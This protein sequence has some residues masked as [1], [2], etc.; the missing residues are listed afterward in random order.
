MTYDILIIGTG[1]SGLYCALNIDKSKKV[2]LITKSKKEYSNSYLAQGG[3]SVLKDS[4]DLNLF[5]EDTLKA[6]HYKNNK[7]SVKTLALESRQ[8]IENLISLGVRFEKNEN[9]LIYT[10]EGAHSTNRIVYHKDITGKEITDTLL[11]RVSLSSNITLLENTKCVDLLTS[12]NSCIGAIIEKNNETEKIYSEFTV[13]ATGGI[14]GLFKN[15]TNQ[16]SITG[17]GLSLALKHN[18][19]LKD[20]NYIQIHPTALYSKDLNKRRF[21]ISESLRGEGAILINSKGERFINE[22]LPRDIVSNAI[23][24]EMNKTKKDYVYL[25]A[26]F[27]SEEFLKNRFPNIVKACLDE[28]YNILKEPIKVSPAQHYFMGGISVDLFGRTSMDNLFSCGETA[29]T[30][31]HGQNRLASNSLLEALVFSKRIANFINSSRGAFIY[32]NYNFKASTPID[33]SKVIDLLKREADFLDDS[34]FKY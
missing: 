27:L 5:I 3:V 8:A 28:G 30:G 33:K 10:K 16:N 15:S 18:I 12:N 4:K 11:D 21:L 29:C 26:D 25:K 34:I 23:F 9:G 17:D 22:L 6:G 24:K 7:E 1:I 2:L 13:L 31:V 20:M 19:I 14:G 32:N